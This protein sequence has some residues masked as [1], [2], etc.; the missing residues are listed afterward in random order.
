M[1]IKNITSSLS[2]WH[3]QQLVMAIEHD[4]V[5]AHIKAE[6]VLSARFCFMVVMACSIA[7]LG[8]LL[9]SPAVVIGAML[10]SPLMA[11][12]MSL[13]FSLS[14]LD[15][16]Q[17]RK[18]L[19]SL[20][21]GIILAIAVSVAIVT[22]S[23]LT[24]ATPEIL[25]RT[26]P[27]LFDLLVAIFSGLAAGYAVI[28]RKGEAIV[29]VAIATALMP[30]LA[31]VGFGFATANTDIYQGA[32]MLFMT[33]LLAIALTV[34]L[35]SKWYG[36]GSDH[37]PKHTLWQ[38]ILIFGIFGALSIP[39][40][41]SLKN[42][43]YQTYITK[44]V[45]SQIYK[46]FE[47]D[48]K[49]SL[50][51]IHFS[52]EKS[53]SVEA[54]VLTPEYHTKAQKLLKTELIKHV[55]QDVQLTLDQIIIAREE[56][57]Q[58][59]LAVSTNQN[60]LT[61]PMQSK[62]ARM[63]RHEEINNALRQAVF[64]PLRLIE[65]NADSNQATIYPKNIK[66]LSL[67]L[68]RQFEQSL[69]D[70]FPDWKISVVPPMQGL[71]YIYFPRGKATPIAESEET[72]N[73]ILWA[74]NNWEV[75][76]VVVVGHASSFKEF[77][78][79]DNISLAY[80]RATNIA[81][82]IEKAGV[83]TRTKSNY[84]DNKQKKEELDFGINNFHRVEVL[85]AQSME[86]I[87]NRQKTMTQTQETVME[88][89]TEIEDVNIKGNL[90][91]N[92]KQ[93]ESDANAVFDIES[94]KLENS[95]IED[96]KPADM[97]EEATSP[98]L[99]TD[100]KQIEGEKQPDN[101]DDVPK[102]EEVTAEEH[103]IEK[104]IQT[105]SADSVAPEIPITGDNDKINREKQTEDETTVSDI[106]AVKTQEATVENEKPMNETENITPETIET[107]DNSL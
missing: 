105:N 102:I 30:P 67:G 16:E 3:K 82:K 103:S 101:A 97:V 68:L 92:K 31:V 83:K 7:I 96:E 12:I 59:Q 73:D 79:F 95:F 61:A 85:L 60:T 33:N 1:I 11:P 22:V 107:E 69:G 14:V 4:K 55:S 40:G 66:G 99:K 2:L 48:S 19:A 94:K 76:E 37:S 45:K 9:S 28:K 72:L 98:I 47:K 78:K 26:Q 34:T 20:M 13:G 15:L 53:L 74:L 88:T 46:I 44:I 62:L 104:E 64:F 42:I 87:L 21:V 52:K 56:L 93:S 58:V 89:V 50:F 23:P 86:T 65:V 41:Y 32:L 81:K 39:L 70:K 17:M 10:I 91:E 106:E 8:L 90:T 77:E 18:A 49:I 43:A 84:Q 75:S 5:I 100:E 36:F 63:S 57:K 51:Q 25:A 71:P 24:E 38:A 54:V 27:N 29:G 6:S 80:E 35:L